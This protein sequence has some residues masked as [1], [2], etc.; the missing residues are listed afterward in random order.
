M[1]NNPAR[2]VRD[3]SNRRLIGGWLFTG[4]ILIFLMVIIGGITRLTGSGLSITEWNPIM[5]AIPPLND[6]EWQVA[7]EKY[8]EIPQFQ[9]IN[10]HFSLHDFKAIFWWE[11]IHRLLGRVIGIVFIIPFVY[12]WVKGMLGKKLIRRLLFLFLLGGL[13]GA[14]GWFMVMSGLSERTSVSH[15]RLA[16][17]LITAFITF[18]FTFYFALEVVIRK[19]QEMPEKMQSPVILLLLMVIVQIVYGAFVAGLHAGKIFNTFPLMGGSVVPDGIFHLSPG[20]SNFFDNPVTVQFI[21]RTLAFLIVILSGLLFW[22]KKQLPETARRGI[23]LLMLV[24]LIQFGLGIWTLL[25]GAE[26]TIS[27]IHQSG[28]FLLFSVCIYLLFLVKNI[29][30]DRRVQSGI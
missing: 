26:I 13:Q 24:V 1:T 27:V 15:I 3:F 9:K 30:D 6:E 20:I 2:P 23:N 4:C 17:H 18:G 12:F 14:I 21:H 25:T 8:Q 19:R 29:S 28:A 10:Y 22:I 5:G 16:I 11:Y 7:F